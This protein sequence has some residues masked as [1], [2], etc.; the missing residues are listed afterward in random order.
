MCFLLQVCGKVNLAIYSELPFHRWLVKI[1]V[2]CFKV[3]EQ[4]SV[5]FVTTLAL[6]PFVANVW[7]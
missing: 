5:L 3:E 1:K 2:Y 7:M 6:H 4:C